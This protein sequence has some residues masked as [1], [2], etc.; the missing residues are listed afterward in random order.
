MPDGKVEYEVRAD[1]S[2]ITR[3]LNEVNQ[4][5]QRSAQETQKKV[6]TIGKTAEKSIKP[7]TEA[8]ESAAESLDNL[9]ESADDTSKDVNKL[10]TEAEHTAEKTEDLGKEAEDAAKKIKGQGEES[11][12]SAEHTEK[13]KTSVDKVNGSLKDAKETIGKYAIAAGA[14]FTAVSAAAIKSASDAETSFA[15]VKTLLS[16]G[17]MVD[18][19]YNRIK[20]ASANTGVSFGSISESVYSAIS[21]SVDESKA[22]EF[23]ENAV[24]LAKGGFTEA[25]T[26]VDVLTTAI[27]AYGL[28]A[29]DATHISDVLIT[30]QNAGKT[31]VDEL[32]RSM[33]QT[34]PIAN[35]AN[36][37]IEEL[38]TA[39]AVMTKNGV[40][41]AEAGTQIKAMLNELNATGSN[42]DKTLR[43]VTGKSFAE[44][45][46]EG[47]TTADVLKTLSDYAESS[48][49]QL[50][51]LFGSMEAGSAAFTLVKDGGA[52][53]ANILDQMQNSAGA[54]EKAYETMSNT[55][56]ERFNKLK[57]RFA[58]AMTGIGE[59][60][61]PHIEKFADYIDEHF[62]EIS[63]TIEDIGK[64]AEG[65]AEFLFKLTKVL[66]DN[67]EVVGSAVAGY[68][69]FKT[70]MSIG[71][72]IQTV[73]SATKNLTAATKTAT[74]AQE[75]MNVACNANP[76]VLLASAIIGVIGALASF[77]AMSADS[78][79]KIT[80][81]SGEVKG[82]A[83]N[84]K[85]AVD[86]Q[87]RL[88]D[89]AAEYERITSTVEDATEKKKQ[90]SELQKTL[91]DL[92]GDEKTGIDL[93]NG[94]YEDNIKLIEEKN[95]LE[96][97]R[98]LN[99]LD[100]DIAEANK[101]I[102]DATGYQA[103]TIDF[104]ANDI[105]DEVNEWYSKYKDE[106]SKAMAKNGYAINI[107]EL[108]GFGENASLQFSGNITEMIDALVQL[109]QSIMD[110]GEAGG[111]LK[112]MFDA[113][114]DRKDELITMRDS[115]ASLEE[116]RRILT[117][118]VQE[119]AETFEAAADAT[120]AYAAAMGFL[121]KTQENLKKQNTELDETAKALID[122]YGS[123]YDKLKD[124]EKGGTLNYEQMK[125]LI[126][127][128]PELESKIALT[129]DGYT[130]E[131][132]ALGD[133]RNALDDSVTATVEA[134]RAKTEAV[135]QGTRE[136]LDAAYKEMSVLAQNGEYTKAAALKKEIEKAQ[137][138]LA[139]TRSQ[140]STWDTLGEY[141][142]GGKGKS[143]SSGSST[144]GSSGSNSG[145]GTTVSTSGKGGDAE[146]EKKYDEEYATLKYRH[147]MG[148]IDDKTFYKGVND[149]KNEYLEENSTKWRS[150]NVS[151]HQYEESLKKEE[152]NTGSKSTA[153]GNGSGKTVISI[154]SYIPTVWD[155]EEEKKAKLKKGAKLDL[156]YK[157]NIRS[158]ETNAATVGSTVASTAPAATASSTAEATLSDVVSA[159][160][161]FQTA[162]EHK[163]ISF[164]VELKARNLTIGKAAVADINDMTNACGKSPLILK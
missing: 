123:L 65:A 119:T 10:G 78:T 54:T 15:K 24:K 153:S 140:L 40:A 75:A 116:Q 11:K 26:A 91:N 159:I 13:L 118:D 158:I 20:A 66:W 122:E 55:I 112:D 16:D 104:N 4:I 164:E 90:L 96:K 71:N 57:N 36:V 121:G 89:V 41:T 18:D 117:E 110:S 155:S 19:Y 32:A 49:K 114:H 59:N 138:E 29:D 99:Q 68:I 124:L 150:A 22:V 86:E 139:N 113:V 88:T 131:T 161:D 144:G 80:Q 38:S 157:S 3:D 152:D 162:D 58:L 12:R 136:R 120:D 37:A 151:I 135:L 149:L 154:D 30:T 141:V 50:A 73:V 74:T 125:K 95:E 47:Q 145:S 70:A 147:D 81:L 103:F 92:Y 6:D 146:N 67:K 69:A 21:A 34:I 7:M 35:S 23:T 108:L 9:G 82:L 83:D 98:R 148:E 14:A 100:A 63:E 31:T 85:A 160:K 2:K 5:V 127:I 101:K 106:M 132:D 17:I 163:K 72:V 115:A 52:D 134:E 28:A 51:D 93:V 143:A 61:M 79:Q 142:K 46:A 53:F 25:A 39:Y 48:G 105:T 156:T 129:A 60:L 77:A 33:G 87:Q 42:V 1:T 44:L 130:L 8:A 133:L 126:E 111:N 94:S 56:E 97:Q 84:A 76:Y 64:A 27:N 109:E 137:A 102:A 43:D 45:K 107:V 128:Y 62:D